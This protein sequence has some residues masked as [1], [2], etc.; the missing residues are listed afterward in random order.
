MF[1]CNALISDGRGKDSLID[2]EDTSQAN[3]KL[4][5]KFS[6]LCKFFFPHRIPIKL[7]KIEDHIITDI[8]FSG[9]WNG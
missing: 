6:G 7:S 4:S 5:N 2:L 1:S 9:W 3:E 8:N